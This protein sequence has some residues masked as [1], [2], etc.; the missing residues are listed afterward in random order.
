M[1]LHVCIACF[2]FSSKLP[3]PLCILCVVFLFLLLLLLLQEPVCCRPA[4]SL[5]CAAIWPPR[6][7]QDT[8]G[9]GSR[10]TGNNHL[11]GKQG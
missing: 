11:V 7:R 10:H 6:Q 9:K 3:P 4:A 1:T 2:C 5:W 8:A